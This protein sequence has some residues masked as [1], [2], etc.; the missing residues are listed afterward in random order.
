MTG[1]L[2]IQL[3]QTVNGVIKAGDLLPGMEVYSYDLEQRKVIISKVK[4]VS[5]LGTQHKL[6]H[7]TFDHGQNLWCTEDLEIGIC[8]TKYYQKTKE[9]DKI[10][11]LKTRFKY[12]KDI[13]RRYRIQ[14]NILPEYMEGEL[15]S[16]NKLF[17]SEI[18]GDLTSDCYVCQIVLEDASN[19]FITSKYSKAEG[20]LVKVFQEE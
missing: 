10:P 17:R 18:D 13:N 5:N 14:T 11:Y 3:V 12:I 6:M 15:P 1:F 16:G 19:L 7:Y 8:E 20:I 9:S 2:N 4:R